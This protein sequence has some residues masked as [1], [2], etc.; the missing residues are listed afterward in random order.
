MAVRSTPGAGSEQRRSAC[1]WLAV[2]P[3]W[4][5]I[6]IHMYVSFLEGFSLFIAVLSFPTYDPTYRF[7]SLLDLFFVHIFRISYYP[8]GPYPL[9]DLSHSSFCA[10]TCNTL[11]YAPA[12]LHYLEK[13]NAKTPLDLIDL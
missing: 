9:L 12:H 10:D 11:Y 3:R 13:K 1:H 8:G 2:L 4:L 7:G 5:Y 6:H